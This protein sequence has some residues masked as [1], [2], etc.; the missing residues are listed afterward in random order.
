METETVNRKIALDNGDDV[1]DGDTNAD[2]DIVRVKKEINI[3]E[4]EQSLLSSPEA[5]VHQVLV[6]ADM[7]E[8][9]LSSSLDSKFS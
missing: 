4:F 3:E 2:F 9:R 7:L 6:T 8:V 1:D 5:Q